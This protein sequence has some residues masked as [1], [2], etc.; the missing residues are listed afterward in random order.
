MIEDLEYQNEELICDFCGEHFLRKHRDSSNKSGRNFCSDLC[1]KQFSASFANTEEKRIQKSKTLKRLYQQGKLLVCGR[2]IDENKKI[3]EEYNSSP[4]ECPICG[5]PIPYEKR[6]CETCSTECSGILNGKH[7]HETQMIRHS[8]GGKR[9][10]SGRGKR[11]WYKGYYCDS[12][13]ELAWVIYNLD[14]GN[15]FKRNTNIYYEYEYGG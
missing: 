11:G 15:Q 3:F 7:N 5:N 14:H 4:K 9:E 6:N 10:G 2:T 1:S 8:S 13:W 12:S